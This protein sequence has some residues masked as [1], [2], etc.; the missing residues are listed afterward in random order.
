VAG[1][2]NAVRMGTLVSTIGCSGFASEYFRLFRDVLPIE[3][4]TVFAFRQGE[5]PAALVA[6]CTSAR[7]GEIVRQLAHEYVAGAFKRDPNIRREVAPTTP[8]VYALRADEVLD[9]DYRQH[10][11]ERPAVS[12]ELVLLGNVRGTLFYSSFYRCRSQ[13][14][15]QRDE[16]DS[17]QQ[18]GYFAMM[19]LERHLELQRHLELE[20]GPLDMGPRAEAAPG[21]SF[22]SRRPALDHLREVLLAERKRLSPREAEVC[23]A[24]VLGYSTLA[25]SLNLGISLNTVATHRKRAYSKLGIC[26]QN[27]L[28][29]QYFR[30]VA[31]FAHESR[32]RASKMEWS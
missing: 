11:Y 9:A 27:E 12:H 10:F 32:P 1:T 25:I 31:Q 7:A 26:S 3:H 16:L 24:I 28:F 18:L 20:S 21:D 2:L 29:S 4:C 30:R 8:L 6:E 14:A 19:A 15:F 22:G 23:A 5:R 17:V 13:S